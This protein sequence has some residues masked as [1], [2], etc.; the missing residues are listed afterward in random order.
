MPDALV[1]L[2]W[3]WLLIRASGV[4]AWGLLTGVV[5]WGLLLR[6]R[7]LGAAATPPALLAT[8]RILGATAL[9]FLALHLGLLLV[10]PVVH[11]N[12][13]QILVPFAAP[14]EPFAVG[15][16]ALALWAL[17]PVSA[18]GRLRQRLGKSGAV[19]FRRSH[20]LAYAAWPLATAHYVLAGTDALAQWSIAAIITASTLLVFAMLVRG[21]V[22]APA[23][24]TQRSEGAPGR[25]VEP[26]FTDSKSAVLPL[27]DPGP[28]A[29]AAGAARTA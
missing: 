1:D 28:R 20:L 17:V 15:L 25:G 19:W 26:L 24:R 23:R 5:L 16:G 12:P 7:L 27:D 13:I 9:G 3:T 29:G 22:P 21:F 6:T 11:F 4:T 18:V 14:W 10:D 8:H 2:P